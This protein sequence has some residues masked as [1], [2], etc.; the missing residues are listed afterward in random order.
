MNWIPI[1]RPDWL[2]PRGNVNAGCPVTIAAGRV[3][4]GFIAETH[5]ADIVDVCSPDSHEW[6]ST[7]TYYPKSISNACSNATWESKVMNPAMEWRLVH[8]S[9]RW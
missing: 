4:S 1:G 6:L 3:N 7:H 2:H 8:G 5:V 9:I